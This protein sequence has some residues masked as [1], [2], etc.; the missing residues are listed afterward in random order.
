MIHPKQQENVDYFSYL[1]SVIANDARCTQKIK[2][3]I[4][5]VKKLSTRRLFRQQVEH[6]FKKDASKLLHLEHSFVWC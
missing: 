2:F 5:L 6:K 4:A 1:G 3:R